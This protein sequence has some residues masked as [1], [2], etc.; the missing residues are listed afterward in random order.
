MWNVVCIIYTGY[1]LILSLFKDNTGVQPTYSSTRQTENA[2]TA[3]YYT[4]I[5][6]QRS[7]DLLVFDYYMFILP[8][9]CVYLHTCC[10]QLLSHLFIDSCQQAERV[11]ILPE[12]EVESN[13]CTTEKISFMLYFSCGDYEDP[14]KFILRHKKQIMWEP[15]R[16]HTPYWIRGL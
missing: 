9:F 2:A 16:L 5:V 11:T 6:C 4:F 8:S 12:N 14:T 13:F 10:R 1:P 7:C 15:D 3:A